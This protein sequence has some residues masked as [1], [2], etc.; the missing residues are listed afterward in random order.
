MKISRFSSFRVKSILFCTFYEF[1]EQD[2]KPLIN[3]YIN[4]CVFAD[5]P[6]LRDQS[7]QIE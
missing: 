6:S 7:G 2:S 3:K 4:I 5:H 1:C